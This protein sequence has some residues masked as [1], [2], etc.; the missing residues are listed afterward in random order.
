[1]LS[2]L[3]IDDRGAVVSTELVLILGVL[4]FGVGSG[5]AAFRDS[6][7]RS[8]GRLGGLVERS[9]PATAFPGVPAQAADQNGYRF[10]RPQTDPS[11]VV[12][13]IIPQTPP[14]AP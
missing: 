13:V 4:T 1:M 9:V 7:N 2:K 6:V 14:P 10:T 11:P 5:L 8:L 3:W 12:I